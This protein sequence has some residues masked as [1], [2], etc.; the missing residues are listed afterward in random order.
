MKQGMYIDM[1][2]DCDCGSKVLWW[3]P[4]KDVA[5]CP[6]CCSRYLIEIESKPLNT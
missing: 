1:D 5:I 3:H 2:Y 4:D 6:K